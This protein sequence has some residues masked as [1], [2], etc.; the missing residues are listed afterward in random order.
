VGFADHLAVYAA[1]SLLISAFAAPLLARWKPVFSGYMVLAALA[2]SFITS[3]VLLKYINEIGTL[4]YFMGGWPPPWGIE[5]TIDPLRVYMLTT[6]TGVSLWIFIY[7]LRDLEHE[8][9]EEVICWYHSLYAILT[10]SMAVMALTN[11]LFNLFVMMEI[12]AITACAL[13]TIKNKKECLEAGFNYLILSAMGSGCFLLGV[14]MIYMVTG[15]LNFSMV[16]AELSQAILLYPLNIYTAAALFIVAFGTKAA[17][18]PLHVWLP[19]AHASAPSPSSAML[20]GLVIKIYAFVLFLIFSRVFPQSLLDAIPLRQII[21]WLGAAG[22]MFGSIYAMLQSDLK[23]MLA[24]SS[25]GQIAFIFMGIGI[26]HSLAVTGGLY[27]IMVHAVTKALLFM[28]AGAVIY[29][30]GVRRISDLTGI[31]KLLPLPMLAFTIGS[32]S[33]IGL[34]GTGGL[35]SKWYLALGS[36]ENGQIFFLLIILASSLLNAVYYMPIVISAFMKEEEIRFE[37]RKIPFSMQLTM[38]L[39]MIMVLASGII[40]RPIIQLIE[41]AV[42]NLY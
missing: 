33:M 41:Q 23:K 29:S 30:T 5:L 27:H 6:I 24:Y 11:D 16:Q 22:V 4:T 40:S 42:I 3:L 19:D 20:S 12:C 26:N 10:A 31:G 38:I 34:P 37:F 9:K 36:L 17:L 18:F 39:G 2:F 8:L 32:A 35:I 14:A 13:I 25:I 21:L 28:A 1:V 7:A 15:Y